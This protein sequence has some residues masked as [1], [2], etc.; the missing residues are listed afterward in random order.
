MSLPNMLTWIR[1][2]IVPVLV[3][4]YYLPFEWSGLAAAALFVFASGT[5]ALDGYLARKLGQTTPS[6]EFL[7]PVAD[8]LL[9]AVAL[10]LIVD[11][12][13]QIGVSI[14]ATAIIW[15]EIA[16]SAL[17][18][19]VGV[20]SLQPLHVSWMGKLKTALQM[21]AITLLL[22][23]VP[24]EPLDFRAILLYAAALM[25]VASM[26]DYVHTYIQRARSAKADKERAGFGD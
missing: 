5:D 25:S 19:W 24:D 21:V 10:I 2:A 16:I 7:D 4:V 3:V 23:S 14:A 8:K 22:F 1:I 17:R 20:Q 26:A 15:R 6:G 13:N 9:I 11:G 12:V 18:Q